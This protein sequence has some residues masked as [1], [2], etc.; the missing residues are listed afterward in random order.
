[1]LTVVIYMYVEN[2]EIVYIST[3]AFMLRLG[4]FLFEAITAGIFILQNPLAAPLL[5]VCPLCFRLSSGR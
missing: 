5:T 3:L 1:M 4:T 2:L